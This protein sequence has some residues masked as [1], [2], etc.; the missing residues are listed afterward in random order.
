MMRDTFN[1]ISHSVIVSDEGKRQL[2]AIKTRNKNLSKHQIYK[3]LKENFYMSKKIRCIMCCL[4]C[5]LL[6]FSQNKEGSLST[7]E[8]VDF[9]LLKCDLNDPAKD[10]NAIDKA[11]K[12]GLNGIFVNDKE[13]TSYATNKGMIAIS[14]YTMTKCKTILDD[15]KSKTKTTLIFSRERSDGYIRNALLEGCFVELLNDTLIGEE[16]WL[17]KLVNSSLDIRTRLIADNTRMVVDITNKSSI[18]YHI[19]ITECDNLKPDQTEVT[20]SP[21][22]QTTLF[23]NSDHMKSPQYALH[24]NISNALDA[25]AKPLR[26]I[27]HLRGMEYMVGAMPQNTYSIIPAPLSIEEK[28]GRFTFNKETRI[29]L[30]D[31]SAEAPLHF[32][33]DRLTQTAQLPI[34]VQNKMGKPSDNYILF[35]RANDQAL[36]DEGYKIEITPESI[37]VLANKEAGFFY[38]IQS[39]LQLLPAE[40]YSNTATYR[41]EWSVP[42]TII[43]DIPQFEYRGLHLDV[44]RHLY[45]VAFIKKYIDL[46]SMQKMNRFH[47]HL[48]EDQGWRIEIKK[49][50]ELTKVGSI[51]KE[52]IINRNSATALQIYDGT[53]YGGFYTQEDIKEIVAYAKERYITII[54]E[55]DLPGHMLAALA[56]YP[57]LGCTGGPYEVGTKWGVYDDVLCA[58]NENIYPFVENILKEVFA[59]FPGEYVHIG[60]DECPK[61]RWKSCSKC[62]AKI[63]ELKLKDEHELQSYVI[64]RVEKYLNANGKKLIGWD[65]ILEGGIAPNAALMSW[66]GVAGGITAAKSKHPVIMTPNTYVYLDHYQANPDLSPL[67]NGR[68]CS[69]ERTYSYDPIPKEL[70]EEEA[71]YIKGIQANVWTEYI[72]TPE[73]VEYMTYPRANAV[74]ETGWSNPEHKNWDNYLSRLQ[75]Q[76]ERW[77]FYGLNC[78]THY[79]GK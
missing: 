4:L 33:I 51:R 34:K 37:Q 41:N 32:L 59:L 15:V 47:W 30:K 14:N 64:R 38:A 45:P 12:K 67:A 19:Q 3:P 6:A 76:F 5:T 65:E 53:P 60:G 63:K 75:L 73:Q 74:A 27:F 31:K 58:G 79:K 11:F 43:T 26:H 50:P 71:S 21:M 42:A 69:L 22:S 40:I 25:K 17:K 7:P 28:Q 68:V 48:T 1:G 9:V 20:L 39:L 35:G 13:L 23:F 16:V 72:K 70:T 78:A 18:P 54:P 8:L 49:Y 56:T 52:T 36:G 46:L 62:Q 55:I 10:K 44:G 66:R 77:R 29:I 57:E 24:T 61:T 2:L